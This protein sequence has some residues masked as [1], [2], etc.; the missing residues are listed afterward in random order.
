VTGTKKQHL[1]LYDTNDVTVS[2]VMSTKMDVEKDKLASEKRCYMM[3][4][5]EKKAS[6]TITNEEFELFKNL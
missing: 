1:T 3:F 5:I 4:L 6:G 2:F